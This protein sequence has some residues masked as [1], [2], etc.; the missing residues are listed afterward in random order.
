[1]PRSLKK[2]P[3]VDDHLLKKVDEQNARNDK[4]VIRTWSR[5]STIFPEMVGH[6]IAVHDGRQ[7]VP[8][9]ISESMVGHKLGEFAPTRSIKWG[10]AGEKQA[11]KGR[12]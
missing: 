6:T 9:F 5:R 7:H 1:M 4:R 11:Q 10:G 8:V 12:R 3:F 2:G